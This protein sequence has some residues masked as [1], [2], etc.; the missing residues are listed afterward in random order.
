MKYYIVQT[1]AQW[2]TTD[3]TVIKVKDVDETNF[4]ETL[5]VGTTVLVEANSLMEALV[6]FEMAMAKHS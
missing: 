5:E 3:F 4:L 2:Q 1:A 6:K